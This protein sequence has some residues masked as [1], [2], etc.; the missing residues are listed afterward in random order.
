VQGYTLREAIRLVDRE[1]LNTP[2]SSLYDK[3]EPDLSSLLVTT[4]D[5]RGSSGRPRPVLYGRR[6][7]P[8]APP[9]VPELTGA[10]RQAL[11]HSGGHSAYQQVAEAHEDL[12]A[13]AADPLGTIAATGGLASC[14]DDDARR[15][16]LAANALRMDAKVRL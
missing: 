13:L 9:A 1:P 7:N 8:P 3:P 10:E 5:T 2:P 6:G 15:K 14:Y 11:F 16:L 12:R 4:D